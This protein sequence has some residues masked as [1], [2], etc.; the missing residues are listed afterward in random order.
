MKCDRYE[1][2]HQVVR[3]A[4][5]TASDY[6][7]SIASILCYL[8]EALDLEDAVFHLLSEDRRHF[9]RT[10]PPIDPDRRPPVSPK[11]SD[12][13]EGRALAGGRP[14]QDGAQW[15]F[16]VCCPRA[17]Y[18]VLSL[19]V[20]PSSP[21]NLSELIQPVAEQLACLAQH[22]LLSRREQRRVGQLT[23]LSE[24]G[25]SLNQARTLRG[26]PQAVLRTVL[27]YTQAACIVIRP[28]SND[29]SLGPSHVRVRQPYR[30]W[31]QRFLDR[32][33][34]ISPAV[35]A[36]GRARFM[37]DPARENGVDD[38]LPPSVAC[39]P[40][41]FQDRVLGT[42][43]LFGGAPSEEEFFTFDSDEK[44]LLSAVASQV[45]NA[46]ERITGREHL[47]T[48]SRERD[49]KLR[50]TTLLYRIS[51]AMH[52]TLRL[53]ELIHL[54]LSA[55]TVPEGGGF[56]RA[57]LFVANERSGTLQGMVG[58]SREG[59]ALV[60]ARQ[61][62]ELRWE[63]PVISREALETQRGTPL[64]LQVKKQRL[65]LEA[66]DNALA[67]A[68]LEGQVVTVHRPESEPPTGAALAEALGLSPY[69]CAPLLGRDRPLGVLVVDNP[70]SREEISP[71][72]V[73]FL[74]LFA[75]QA[76]GAM[77]N[78]ML[79]HQLESA[80]ND[81][82]ETQ[83]R[84]L[85]G[86]KM[87]VLGEMAASVAHELRN[88]LVPIGGFARRLVRT[89]AEGSE[90]HQYAS[91]VARETERMEEML[92]NILAFSKRQMLCFTDCH[93]AEVL[94]EALTLEADALNR[95]EIDLVREVASDL[96][97][98]QGDGQKLRQVMVNLIANARQAMVGG[99][100]LTLRV[101]RATLRGRSAVTVE[102]EDTG[103]GIPMESLRNI[104]NPFF[105]TKEEGT[106]LGLSI[107]HRIIEHHQGEIEVVNREL[108]AVF[109]LRLP[110]RIPRAPYR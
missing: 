91:I 62:G 107:S 28:L 26:L 99:G 72:R 7:Q 71:D 34:E 57:M 106:G 96:P 19:R 79:L 6:P 58:V 42:L 100:S 104:F 46:L 36:G 9:S 84:M 30:H 86:E 94:D 8:T 2:L 37:R 24:L 67:R 33:A 97:V 75:N 38:P 11:L 105:T 110:V 52:S 54:I 35:F 18:G 21:E 5:C 88:P 70:D 10:F 39:L 63:R 82:R 25:R 95:S 80:H 109:I 77:E 22:A 64:C 47:G 31:R 65:P 49:R 1:V 103:G 32:D 83:E 41:I 66:E 53:N 43:T 101:Y 89:V 29:E 61:D 14:V 108:G 56:E 90:E 78:S 73:R 60:L 59:A 4:S 87:A 15:Y 81:L 45:A 13:P 98:I 74:E 44:R 12:S 3:I 48:I 20:A 76:G 50:E 27:R 92:A 51:R 102:V 17:D 55:A 93:L 68:A 85:H 69:A 23:L 40:L 16:P